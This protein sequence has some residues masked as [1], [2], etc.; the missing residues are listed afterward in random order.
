MFIFYFLET[1]AD[2]S[3]PTPDL[4]ASQTQNID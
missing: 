4:V 3:L 2:R 1:A